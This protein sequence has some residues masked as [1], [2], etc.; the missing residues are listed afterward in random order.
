MKHA[1]SVVEE[2][3]GVEIPVEEIGYIFNYVEHDDGY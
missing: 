1:F 2:Y 3:Y